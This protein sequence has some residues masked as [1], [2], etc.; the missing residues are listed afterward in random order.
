[1]RQSVQPTKN[2]SPGCINL[3]WREVTYI[4]CC[5]LD[6]ESKTS[7][8]FTHRHRG[9][10]AGT[11]PYPTPK[12]VHTLLEERRNAVG[13]FI[14]LLRVILAQN[15]YYELLFPRSLGRLTQR[16]PQQELYPVLGRYGLVVRRLDMER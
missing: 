3:D 11:L 16:Q 13:W 2:A 4:L 14:Y 1:M 12:W 15:S 5:I 10:L 9:S 7:V 6:L 8:A